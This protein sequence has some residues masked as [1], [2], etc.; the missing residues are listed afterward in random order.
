MVEPARPQSWWAIVGSAA[1]A[2]VIVAVIAGSF[3]RVPYVII[4]PGDATPLDDDVVTVDGPRTHPHDGVFLFL[5]VQLTTRDP[6]VWRWLFAKLDDN[7]TIE[8]RERV[9][10]CASYAQSSRLNDLLMRESQDHAKTVALRRL[11][12]EV[13]QGPTSVVIVDVSCDSPA[14]DLLSPG[15]FVRGVDGQAVQDSEQIRALVA[16]HAPGET[17]DVLV[18]RDGAERSVAIRTGRRTNNPARPCVPAD[19]PGRGGEACVGVVSQ[20]LVDEEYPFEIRIDTRRVSG[21]SAGLAFALSVIDD[22]TPGELTGGGRVAVTGEILPDGRVGLVGGIA[23]KTA[24]A[25]EAGVTLLIVPKGEAKLARQHA[26]GLQ[27]VAVETLDEAL[28]ALER[29]GG[30]PIPA[31]PGESTTQ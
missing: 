12:Y 3:I 29:F 5:T 9:I 26:D 24:A 22:L 30:D 1:L 31:G 28:T 25:R 27:V 10:G 16:A 7:V 18:E 23:Q 8:K 4:S 15:D 17:V 2:L 13:V 11:G 19:S 20:P 21:P 14:S 6:T